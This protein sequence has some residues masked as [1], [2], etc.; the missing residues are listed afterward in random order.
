MTLRNLK[1]PEGLSSVVVFGQQYG[2]DGVVRGVEAH[3]AREIL[4][5]DPRITEFAEGGP[6]DPH[7]M[8]RANDRRV[9]AM[10]KVGSMNRAELFSL[11]KAMKLAAPATSRTETLREALLRIIADANEED[12]PVIVGATGADD[13]EAPSILSADQQ[14]APNRGNDSLGQKPGAL[15]PAG[16]ATFT[17]PTPAPE[18]VAPPQVFA[19]DDPRNP[20]P[21]PVAEV[22]IE[23][24]PRPAV[25]AIHEAAGRIDAAVAD[26]TKPADG[27]AKT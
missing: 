9:S 26:A 20:A 12:I 2:A 16:G 5:H 13:A 18:P 27:S 17:Q 7:A 25:V 6:D 3:V 1:L 8:P 4:A 21:A 15:S 24:D 19:A 23:E 22:T 11:S 10:A 14:A